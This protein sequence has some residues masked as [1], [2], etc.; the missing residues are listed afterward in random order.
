MAQ[1]LSPAPVRTAM[2]ENGIMTREWTRWFDTV[3]ARVGGTTDPVSTEIGNMASDTLPNIV[4]NEN[5]FEGYSDISA[6]IQASLDLAPVK[7]VFG[8]T[9]NITSAEGDYSLTQLSDVTLSSPAT[10]QALTFNGTLWA[11]SDIV[12]S[13]TGTANQISITSST[14]DI[15]FS[16]PDNMTIGGAA[17]VINISST[18]A[19]SSTITG[20]L[21]VGGG[22]GVAGTTYSA[23][24]RTTTATASSSKFTGS[25]LSAGGIGANGQITATTLGTNAPTTK[26][27]NYTT[28]AADSSLIFNGT[29]SITLTLPTASSFSGRWLYLKNVAAFTVVSASSN[30]VPLI[31]GAAGTAI[32]LGVQGSWCALQSDGVNWIKMMGS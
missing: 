24:L 23:L 9:G 17:G 11:N 32:L 28:V 12:N 15:T 30:V 29:G 31:G 25:I 21:T 8:R 6:A 4:I 5:H 2:Y 19:S 10:K 7:S 16:L 20:A 1:Q 18:V 3:Y 27:G 13:A 26:T 14:G 22:V